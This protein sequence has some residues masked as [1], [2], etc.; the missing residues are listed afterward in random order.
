VESVAPVKIA[1]TGAKGLLGWHTAARMHA[2]T[3]A[4]R[5]RGEEPQHELVAIDR[6]TFCDPEAL[7]Q[8]L[9]GADAVLHFAGINRGPEEEVERGNPQIAATLAAGCRAA[10]IAPHIVYANSTHAE[11]D[12]FYGRSKR[13]AGETLKASAAAYTDLVLPHVFGECARPDYNNVTATLIDRLWKGQ[14]PTIDPAGRVELLHAG[15]AAQTAI[16]AALSGRT[17]RIR[18]EGRAM[19]VADLYDKLAGFQELYRANTFPDLSDPFDL[20]LF[21]AFRTGGYPQHYPRPLRMNADKRGVLFESAKGGNASHTFLSTTLPGVTRGDHFHLDLVERFVVVRGEAVIR[22]RKVLD[23]E[24]RE[25]RVSGEQPVAIDQLPLHTH[26]IENVGAEELITFFW[27][28]RMFDPANPDT[29][30]D[31]VLG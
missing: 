26:S 3:C 21:N 14:E 29:Y 7:A 27:S 9:I 12:T 25:F 19:S 18:P 11:R 15:A 23:S 28:H 4:A 13:I 30:S 2:L 5:Y 17:G 6:A 31:P 1:V 16:D 22:I 8:A 10:G 20:A 24:I